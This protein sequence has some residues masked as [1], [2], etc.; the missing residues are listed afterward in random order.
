MIF[1]CHFILRSPPFEKSLILALLITFVDILII[2]R[3][4]S[5]YALV[6]ILFALRVSFRMG[7]AAF[8]RVLRRIPFKQHI[9]LV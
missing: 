9:F 6:L 1:I 7:T 3:G 8:I 5:K 4:V 2:C